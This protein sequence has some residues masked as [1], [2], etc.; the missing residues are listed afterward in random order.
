MAEVS[1]YGCV[2]GANVTVGRIASVAVKKVKDLD[3][4][5]RVLTIVTRNA[6]LTGAWKSVNAEVLMGTVNDMVCLTVKQTYLIALK[7][8]SETM[9]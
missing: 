9:T 7:G 5:W 4:T 3:T 2:K 1:G 8:R 6:G